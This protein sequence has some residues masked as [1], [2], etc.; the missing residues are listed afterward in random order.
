MRRIATPLILTLLAVAASSVQG[1]SAAAIEI[2]GRAFSNHSHDGFNDATDTQSSPFFTNTVDA[3]TNRQF[4]IGPSSG[5]A[6]SI[7]TPNG[8]SA[9]L[10]G[11]STTVSG[12]VTINGNANALG[13]DGLPDTADDWR[14]GNSIPAGVSL[15]YTLSFTIASQNGANLITSGTNTGNGLAIA[16]NGTQ[17]YGALN[18]G[19]VLVISAITRGE[20]QWS[21]APTANYAFTP[22][23]VGSTGFTS[24]RAGNFPEGTTGATLSDGTDTWGFG[25]STGTVVDNQLIK[26]GF[27]M[28]E[29]I[30]PSAGGALPLTL[31]TDQGSWNLKGFQLSTPVSYEVVALPPVINADFNGDSV[32]DGNDF[33]A[34]QRNFTLASGATREQGDADGNGTVDELDLAAW[35]ENFGLG[36]DPPVAA[37]AVPEPATATLAVV[38]A[39]ATI[40]TLRARNTQ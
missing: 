15:S 21:G 17:N 6:G 30:F 22:I 34:W 19:E 2:T 5:L 1:Q 16:N 10:S 36:S 4:T 31:T 8:S 3:S 12:T 35:K 13:A 38:A 7:K 29:Y 33:L 39:L 25:T 9:S 32:V 26:N 28:P 18:V 24:F 20:A 14:N 27:G 11:P 40:L 23:S 37:A